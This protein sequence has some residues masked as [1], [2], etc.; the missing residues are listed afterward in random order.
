MVA[1]EGANLPSAAIVCGESQPADRKCGARVGKAAESELRM[2]ARGVSSGR[3][4]GATA[5]AAD[6]LE[7]LPFVELCPLKGDLDFEAK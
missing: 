6:A 2:V 5:I 7:L 3:G 1:A 4:G